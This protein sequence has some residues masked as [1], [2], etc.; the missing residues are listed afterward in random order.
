MGHR[1]FLDSTHKYRHDKK[2]FDGSKELEHKPLAR[3]GS[4]L[5]DQLKGIRFK[6]GKMS[7]PVDGVQKKTWRKWSIFFE[8]PYW[9][10]HLI[11]HNLDPIHIET[12]ICG[13]LVHTLLN[14]D[15]KSKDNLGAH[16]DL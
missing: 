11:N 10:H 2:S 12:N 13:N 14:V 8:L 7:E 1:C 3:S 5:L 9:E 4:D 16:H 6:F 15:K